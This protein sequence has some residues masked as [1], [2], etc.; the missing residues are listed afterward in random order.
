M[1][2]IVVRS[3]RQE[4]S[5]AAALYSA[6]STTSTLA[7]RRA[8]SS[9]PS[10]ALRLRQDDASCAWSPGFEMPSSGAVRVGGKAV[11]RPGSGSR[12]GVPTIRVV[13]RGRRCARTSPSASN[14]RA[15][16]AQAAMRLGARKYLEL[17]GMAGTQDSYPHQLSGGM[18]QRV[19]IARSY[20]I[21]PEVLLMDEPFG[22]LDAQTRIV[23][24]EELIRVSR[25]NP[26]TVLFITHSVEE[27]VI[28]PTASSCFRAA[29]AG[30]WRSSRVRPHA[31]GGEM[32]RQG[33]R[34]SD[35]DRVVSGDCARI[36][37][38]C[39]ASRCRTDLPKQT[40][41][42]PR[43]EDDMRKTFVGD[44][45][46]LSPAASSSGRRSA[47]GAAGDVDR[48][49]LSAGGLLGGALLH[50]DRE[51]LV[52][53]GR[54]RPEVHHFPSGAPQVAA[55]ASKSWDVG[56]T[57][58]GAGSARFAALQHPDHRHHQ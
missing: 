34:G 58:F 43:K 30:S 36:S 35:G 16:T 32:G 17:M 21:E 4:C 7:I 2:D 37:G 9:S 33:E 24:Q 11:T 12:R 50:R 42:V 13:S 3:R 23:M 46:G 25:V 54:P 1:S 38:G 29:R 15:S 55:A 6:R 39:C 52:E 45:A 53:G 19:A 14:A 41:D 27:A 18:Q 57:G 26:R 49:E 51:G 48:R 10:S 31:R 20:A 5:R 8:R 22:A 47:V 56:G 40:E 28:S 44:T